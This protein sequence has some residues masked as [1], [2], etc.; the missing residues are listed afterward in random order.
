MS[1]NLPLAVVNAMADE[2][3]DAQILRLLRVYDAQATFRVV[4]D[5]ASI[6]GP[7]G[8]TYSPFP[9]EINLPDDSGAEVPVIDVQVFDL[10]QEI[11]AEVVRVAG[12]H[13]GL[14]ADFFVVQRGVTKTGST[15]H[16]PLVEYVGYE[17]MEATNNETTLQFT[18]SLRAI[19]DQP[20]AKHTF[21]PGAFPGLF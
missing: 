17:V 15:A 6:V 19:L 3:T 12:L 4:D 1:R 14:Q 16:E 2:N 5:T 20:L 9:F 7:D 13:N 18:M 10:T 21:S 8:E 11:V